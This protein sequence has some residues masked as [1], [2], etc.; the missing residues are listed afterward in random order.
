MGAS[1]N[2]MSM[3]FDEATRHLS[4]DD[5]HRKRLCIIPEFMRPEGEHKRW[6]EHLPAYYCTRHATIALQK[7][8]IRTF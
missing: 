7:P 3:V 6:N 5:K 8:G 4:V 1:L 2:V